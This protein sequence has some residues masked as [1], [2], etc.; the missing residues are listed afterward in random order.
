MTPLAKEQPRAR[1]LIAEDEMLVRLVAAEALRDLGYEVEEA[2]DGREALEILKSGLTIDL[3]ISDV[4][5]P[6]MGG[7][8]L[9]EAGSAVQP[10]MRVMMMTGYSHE[11]VPEKISRTGIKVLQKPFDIDTLTAAAEQA[12]K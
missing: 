4:K 3:L 2:A 7:Y 11:P 12:L 10:R 9:V 8:E 6:N 1:V 5:M